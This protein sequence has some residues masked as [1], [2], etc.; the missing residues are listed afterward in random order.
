MATWRPTQRF[1]ARPLK[2]TVRVA[3]RN[4]PINM[5]SRPSQEKMPE[6]VF[7]I[8]AGFHQFPRTTVLITGENYESGHE[9]A[10]LADDT[11]S[12][13]SPSASS[14]EAD[15]AARPRYSSTHCRARFLNRAREGIRSRCRSGRDVPSETRRAHARIDMAR[16]FLLSWQGDRH[17]ARVDAQ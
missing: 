8:V 2:F 1:H 5:L 12:L 17:S 15:L 7:V 6:G 9:S 4:P 10:L 16:S 3:N 13:P 11:V 14:W